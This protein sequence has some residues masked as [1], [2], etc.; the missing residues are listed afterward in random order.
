MARLN[1]EEKYTTNSTVLNRISRRYLR[2]PC[3]RPHERENGGRAPRTE[4]Y[5]NHRQGIYTSL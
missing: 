1:T 3:S 4:R 5:K 2:D